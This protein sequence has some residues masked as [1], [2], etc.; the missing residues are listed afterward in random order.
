MK[1]FFRHR[2]VSLPSTLRFTLPKVNLS[3]Y[4]YQGSLRLPIQSAIPLLVLFSYPT[5]FVTYI[6]T[7]SELS[8]QVD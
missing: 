4:L 8:V 6:A 1:V 7:P 3:K 2:V 5:T